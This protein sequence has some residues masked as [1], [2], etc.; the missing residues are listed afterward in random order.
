M[1]WYLDKTQPGRRHAL[2]VGRDSNTAHLL[3]YEQQ[4]EDNIHYSF[5]MKKDA[6]FCGPSFAK[7]VY[8]KFEF[9]PLIL[10]NY[11][12]VAAKILTIFKYN[13]VINDLP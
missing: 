10:A 1:T 3:L 5:I 7:C 2:H 11:V 4:A 8:T 9:G 13:S 12:T 6:S